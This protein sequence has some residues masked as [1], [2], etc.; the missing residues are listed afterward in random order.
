MSLI[1]RN[2]PTNEIIVFYNDR[3][4]STQLFSHK[5]F[6]NEKSLQTIRL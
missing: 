5:V 4:T 1:K 2:K 3:L 6:E